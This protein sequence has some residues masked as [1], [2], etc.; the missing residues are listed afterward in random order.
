LLAAL[1][2]S[3][4][5][6]LGSPAL[7][8]AGPSP[9]IAPSEI[10]LDQPIGQGEAA[11]LP[12]LSVS[13]GGD[14]R[15]R[16]VM[17]VTHIG[18]QQERAGDSAWIEFDPQRF[19]LGPGEAQPV[20]VQVRIPRDAT[21]GDYRL[22]LRARAEAQQGLAVGATISPAVATT[23]LFTVENRD[24]QFYDSFV[25]F[26]QDRAPFSYIA[27]GL[28]VGL[29]AVLLIRQRLRFR[30]SFGVERRE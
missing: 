7:A 11:R 29:I 18:G 26:F 12:S 4:S 21:P 5:A 20:S 30:I 6:L 8:L 13:N 23:L 9:G 19:D 14:A 22:L 16:F 25:D 15:A 17:D 3:A 1:L 27:L 24:F 2:L 10:E 28:I